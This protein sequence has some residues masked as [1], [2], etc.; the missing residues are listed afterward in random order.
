[1]KAV[2]STTCNFSFLFLPKVRLFCLISA[3]AVSAGG[4]HGLG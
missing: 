3:R 4:Y 1:L 2:R